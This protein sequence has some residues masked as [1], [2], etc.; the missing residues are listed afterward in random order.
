MSYFPCLSA[1]PFKIYKILNSDIGADGLRAS[2][3]REA[4]YS[5]VGSAEENGKRVT[6]VLI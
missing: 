1:K 3:S 2:Y 5:F 4:E 6:F